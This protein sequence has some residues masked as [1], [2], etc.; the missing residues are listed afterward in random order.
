MKELTIQ[1]YMV[2]IIYDNWNQVLLAKLV[3]IK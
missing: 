2:R 1:N 3:D